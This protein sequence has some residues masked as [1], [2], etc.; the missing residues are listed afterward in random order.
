MDASGAASQVILAIASLEAKISASALTARDPYGFGKQVGL[1]VDSKLL[2]CVYV[3]RKY[4]ILWD[5]PFVIFA[6]ETCIINARTNVTIAVTIT[7]TMSGK[8]PRSLSFNCQATWR[9]FSSCNSDSCCSSQR[10]PRSLARRQKCRPT[11][12]S[13]QLGEYTHACVAT[14]KYRIEPFQFCVFFFSP[15]CPC[16]IFAW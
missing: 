6:P 16:R 13:V 10:R 2:V 9:R 11:G 15:T 3:D 12:A 14:W 4:P 5:A 7:A 8:P 1:Q